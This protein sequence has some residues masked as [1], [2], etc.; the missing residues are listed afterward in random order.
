MLLG[1]ETFELAK[2]FLDTGLPPAP[3]FQ[4]YQWLIE[5]PKTKARGQ[6]WLQ[7]GVEAGDVQCQQFAA[8]YVP[9]TGRAIMRAE[10]AEEERGR[11]PEV[12][13][14]GLGWMWPVVAGKW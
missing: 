9:Q 7:R 11:E 5:S 8:A 13:L 1:E 6:K 2:E 10:E 12:R 14:K 3:Y 4:L